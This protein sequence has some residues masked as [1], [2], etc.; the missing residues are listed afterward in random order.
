M[1]PVDLY[2]LLILELEYM[3]IEW[4]HPLIDVGSKEKDAGV[5]RS[6]RR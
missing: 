5:W 2:D 1:C 4:K 3:K 6:E